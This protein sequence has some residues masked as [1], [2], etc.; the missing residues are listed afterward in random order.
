LL[1]L[2]FERIDEVGKEFND[3]GMKDRSVV[4]GESVVTSYV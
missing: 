3:E 2:F 4:L 1:L